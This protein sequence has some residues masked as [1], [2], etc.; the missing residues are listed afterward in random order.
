MSILKDY[1][2]EEDSRLKRAFKEMLITFGLLTVYCIYMLGTGW[3]M[4]MQK[5]T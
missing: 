1:G 4:G 5:T 2:I 3:W